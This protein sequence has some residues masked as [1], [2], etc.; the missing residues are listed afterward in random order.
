MD[1]KELLGVDFSDPL[2]LIAYIIS[3]IGFI[4]FTASTALK[5]KAMILSFQTAGNVFCGVSEIM[6]GAWTGLAQE[7]INGIRNIFVLKK[8]MN[9]TLSIVFVFLSFGVGLLVFIL[10]FQKE[11]WWGL[12]PMIATVQYSIV[13]IIPNVGVAP[14]KLSL[15]AS[16]SCWAV[17]GLSVKMY[18]T[19]FF[20]IISFILALVTLIIYLVNKNKKAKEDVALND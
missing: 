20:N 15:M 16:S 8:W 10:A 9:K 18:T 6:M 1:I 13:I 14:I 19:T 11:G 3:T 5:R 2:V 7:V 17:Y 12:L 4:L